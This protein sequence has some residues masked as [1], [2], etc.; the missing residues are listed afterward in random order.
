MANAERAA[1]GFIMQAQRTGQRGRLPAPLDVELREMRLHGL[2]R[3]ILR[4]RATSLFDGSRATS[5]RARRPRSV[6]RFEAWSTAFE[7]ASSTLPAIRRAAQK[8]PLS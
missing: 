2:G 3:F 5:A 1:L 8:A 4:G 6:N 7:A